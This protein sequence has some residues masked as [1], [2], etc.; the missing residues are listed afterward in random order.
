MMVIMEFID[1]ENAF[2]HFQGDDLPEKVL[3]DVKSAVRR[4]HDMDLVFG[5]L[6]R[7]S[8]LV[9]EKENDELCG[10]LFDFEWVGEAGLGRYSPFLNNCG[11]MKCQWANGIHPYGIMEKEHDLKMIDLLNASTSVMFLEISF[12]NHRAQSCQ[13]SIRN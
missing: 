2:Q 13:N 8:I 7:P 11:Q 3:N 5:N 9:K 6:R 10:L 1:C 4:L 12:P